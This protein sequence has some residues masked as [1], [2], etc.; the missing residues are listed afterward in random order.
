MYAS[1]P[2]NTSVKL[3]MLHHYLQLEASRSNAYNS[4]SINK[5]LIQYSTHVQ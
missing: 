1:L 2:T 3:T 5:G 4:I